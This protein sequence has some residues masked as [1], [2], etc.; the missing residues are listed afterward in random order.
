MLSTIRAALRPAQASL[1]LR[2]SQI[3]ATPRRWAHQSYGNEQSGQAQGTDQKNP[4][5]HL[6]HPGPESP[7]AAKSGG[8]S[9]QSSQSTT[10]SNSDDG[11]APTTSHGGSPKIHQ[12][13][14][15]A[16]EH[17]PEVKKHNEE[18]AQR[19][20]KT[21]NQLSEGDN[22]VDKNYWKGELPS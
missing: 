4:K 7:A 2:S 3:A 16:E 12:P 11:S 9:S 19:Y 5:S 22:K 18:L 21:A 17:D 1:L 6:E 14:S 15:A 8:G 13:K 10:G 20:E